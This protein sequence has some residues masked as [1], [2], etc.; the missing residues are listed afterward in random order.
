MKAVNF[1]MFLRCFILLVSMLA[2]FTLL[3]AQ[4]PSEKPDPQVNIR[5]CA[6][7]LVLSRFFTHDFETGDLSGWTK[8]GTAFDN[9]PTYGDIGIIRNK[10]MQNWAKTVPLGGDYWKDIALPD[11]PWNNGRQGNYW[12]G[13]S[14]NHPRPSDSYAARIDN[15]ARTGTLISPTFYLCDRKYISFLLSGSSGRVELLVLQDGTLDM[16]KISIPVKYGERRVGDI[17]I[18]LFRWEDP[19]KVEIEGQTYYVIIQEAAGGS[20]FF[21]R[22]YFEIP[23]YISKNLARL[24]FVDDNKGYI[25]IDDIRFH[26]TKSAIPA[27]PVDPTKTPLWGFVDMH[28]HPMTHVAFGGKLIHGAPDVG[29]VLPR[30]HDCNKDREASSAGAALT[31]CNAT[32]G[33]PNLNPFHLYNL[34]G[35]E[36]RKKV[37][38]EYEKSNHAQSAHGADKGGSPT[39][40]YWPRY[41]DITH[42]QMWIDWVKRT[43]EGGLRVMVALCTNSETL[44]NSVAGPSD[45][46]TDDASSG[47]LQLYYIQKMV[48]RHNGSPGS[49]DNW[50][51]IA[52]SPQELRRI[53][54][55][56]RL[57]IVLGV[58]LDDIGNFI[59]NNRIDPNANFSQAVITE[60]ERLYRSGVRYIFPIHLIDNKFGGT[61]TYEAVFNMANYIHSGQTNWWTLLPDNSLNFSPHIDD[62]L[63]IIAAATVKMGIDPIR[64]VNSAKAKYQLLPSASGYKNAQGLTP[65]GRFAINE[66]AKRGMMIDID[67]MSDLSV[68]DVISMF[69]LSDRGDIS[70]SYPINSGHNGERGAGGKER[71]I[72][73]KQMEAIR[74]SGGFFGVG[75]SDRDSKSEGFITSLRN[76]MQIAN[77]VS[78]G[79]Y[80][81]G[82]GTDINGAALQPMHRAGSVVYGGVSGFRPCT[83][84]ESGR[85]AKT[86]DYNKE[87][88][89]HYGLIPDIFQDMK[90]QG[91][92][93]REFTAMFLGAEYFAQMWEKCEIQ[94]TKIP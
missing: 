32:H 81:I 91:M 6:G 14:D 52:R 40:T 85:V 35:D 53:V 46:Q 30:D 7:R 8:T 68:N 16:K 17:V 64:L 15:H 4:V 94:K 33:G 47:N 13:T 76:T 72:T 77:S 82:L 31:H 25:N 37:I 60:I 69:N 48:A 2:T 93:T 92:T 88:L 10:K 23:E 43:W 50:M 87:G 1:L 67:H 19:P 9:Q 54:A 3:D 65:L 75:W 59:R 42:Q 44:G 79:K 21:H 11:E 83:F 71:Q 63:L 24:R 45:Y 70:K 29:I 86:W 56:G 38:E 80:F 18:P 66:M 20:D 84:T 78:P 5:D 41:N 58:E 51:E 73:R 39:F 57:A 89:A 34:C 55:S 74:K 12:V 49:I 62:A 36:I 26:T 90:G 27:T 22:S 61:A 28:A